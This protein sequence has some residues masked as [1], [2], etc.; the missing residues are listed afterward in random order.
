M[1]TRRGSEVG[2]RSREATQQ[3]NATRQRGSNMT[4]QHATQWGNMMK[5]HKTHQDNKATIRQKQRKEVEG[6]K[7]NES[8][9]RWKMKEKKKLYDPNPNSKFKQHKTL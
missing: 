3:S 2:Q 7:K 9:R 8:E 4:K 1:A 5:Q 6:E